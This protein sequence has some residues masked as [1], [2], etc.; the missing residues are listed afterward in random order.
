MSIEKDHVKQWVVQN[1]VITN[2]DKE[3]W[4]A[5]VTIGYDYAESG[6]TIEKAYIALTNYIYK[7][8]FILS[9]LQHIESFKKIIE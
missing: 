2:P 4:S 1:A 8:P 5:S 7:S 9:Q 3:M 6:T